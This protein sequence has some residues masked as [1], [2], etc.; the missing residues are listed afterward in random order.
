MKSISWSLC[1]LILNFLKAAN[2]REACCYCNVDLHEE[3]DINTYWQINRDVT[4]APLESILKFIDVK[5]VL[6]DSLHLLLRISDFLFE[7]CL[8]KLS[9]MDGNNSAEMSLRPNLQI[10]LDFL[11]YNCKLTNPSYI[12][13]NKTAFRNFTGNERL[14]IF[15]ELFRNEKNITFGE[16]LQFYKKNG[17]VV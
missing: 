17:R 8:N 7:L 6:I 10:F 3:P 13:Q 1:F 15:K 14:K 11:K 9:K 4:E 5:K 2:S 16:P 12:S